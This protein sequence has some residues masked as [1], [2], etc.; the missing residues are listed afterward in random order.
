MNLLE[1]SGPLP[2]PRQPRFPDRPELAESEPP[3]LPVDAIKA[4][5]CPRAAKVIAM[6]M[7]LSE[8]HAIADAK[9]PS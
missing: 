6:E 9:A 2:Q 3:T 5:R 1:V 4:C 7:A 8:V